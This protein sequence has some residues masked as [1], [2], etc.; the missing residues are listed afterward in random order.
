MPLHASQRPPS[1]PRRLPP[2]TPVT[3][4]S[5]HGSG[6]WEAHGVKGERRLFV[7]GV[8]YQLKQVWN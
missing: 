5:V 1:Q 7:V 6:D 8:S 2:M 3:I 4:E